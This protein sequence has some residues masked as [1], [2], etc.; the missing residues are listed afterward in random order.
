MIMIQLVK[1]LFRNITLS[2]GIIV[3][4]KRPFLKKYSLLDHKEVVHV[5][6]STLWVVEETLVEE[7]AVV[8]V[9]AAEVVMEKGMGI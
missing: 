4:W 8:E 5:E 7:E 9:V 6:L 1:L 3:K 2:M